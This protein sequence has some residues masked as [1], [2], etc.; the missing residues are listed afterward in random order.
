MRYRWTLLL[1]SLVVLAISRPARCAEPIW[2][3]RDYGAVGDG[4]TLNTD[5]FR[6]AI[7]ACTG[8]GGGRVVVPAGTFLTGPIELKSSVNLNLDENAIILYSR[9]FDDYPLAR[10]SWEGRDTV[11]CR[12][13]LWGENLHD[14]S[15]T[16]KGIIDGQG[17]GWRLVQK[18][19]LS[20]E[21]WDAIVKSGGVVD[22]RRNVWYPSD[23]WRTGQMD[24][25]KLR[26]QPGPPN[27]DDYIKYKTLLR[28]ALVLLTNCHDVL[29]SGPTFRNS[30]SWNIHLLLSDNVTVR[31]VTIFNPIYAQNGDGI[32]ID[33]CRNVLL[34][35]STISAGDDDICLKS[36]RD[37]EGRKLARPTENITIS[38]CVVNWG[39]G[40]VAIGSEMSGGIRNVNVSNCIFKG[41]DCGLRFKTTRGRGGVV[42]NIS[43]NNV[44]MSDIR[45]A[46]I[47]LD[48]YYMIRGPH[49]PAPVGDGT[50]IFRQF[51]FRNITCQGAVRAI[52]IH[53]LPE[54][55]IEGL[56]FEGLRLS[57]NSGA[58]IMDAKD[59]I[60]RDVRIDSRQAPVLQTQD[61][62]N[63]TTE[64]LSTFV[65]TTLPPI[66]QPLVPPATGPTDAP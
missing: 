17:D 40:G 47:L 43:V 11:A 8:A 33:S 5:A 3:I 24:L 10:V 63:L 59:I 27:P 21:Q 30:P 9:N 22:T 41:T 13:P 34:A 29:L 54:L 14:V 50:P 23:I 37:E 15:V 65:N 58:E 25:A 39:H 31:D 26:N 61:V 66:S 53:G 45:G 1:M 48:M 20:Q 38:N 6:K 28:P 35:D 32:D 57:A 2:N 44:T 64:L 49:V 36:G 52:Q 18:A 19:K 42:E 46:A 16:G 12:S 4:K 60:M 56:T 51:Q 62:Q 55:P 7:E